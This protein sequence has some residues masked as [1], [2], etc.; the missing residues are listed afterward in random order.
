MSSQPMESLFALS[1]NDNVVY[2]NTFSRTISPAMR[3][4][5]MVIPKRLTEDFDSRP[6]FIRAPFLPL[7]SL[8]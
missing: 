2:L 7:N 4:G 5:Y 3:I 6:G 8:F 1:D